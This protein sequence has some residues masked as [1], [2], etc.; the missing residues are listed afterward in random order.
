MVVTKKYSMYRENE[1]Q[2]ANPEDGIQGLFFSTYAHVFISQSEAD[3]DK[4]Q[5]SVAG[6][7]CSYRLSAETNSGG[8]IVPDG[9]FKCP[10][11]RK[12]RL[13]GASLTAYRSFGIDH[14]HGNRKSPRGCTFQSFIFVPR[15][16]TND[17]RHKAVSP[18]HS[19][20]TWVQSDSLTTHWILFGPPTHR[21]TTPTTRRQ[22]HHTI[23]SLDTMHFIQIYFINSVYAE[24]N[25]KERQRLHRQI[26]L[27]RSDRRRWR[28][29]VNI[30]AKEKKLRIR[31]RSIKSS[32]EVTE[33]ERARRCE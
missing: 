14:Q 15:P 5:P 26:G 7:N 31:I 1:I 16:M 22:Y 3:N 27:R 30:P 19:W 29:R 24:K 2:K 10:S 12:P 6:C 23:S 21:F 17:I 11:C 28:A 32:T 25:M 33:E 20:W 9:T 13:Q 4:W 8:G 18:R